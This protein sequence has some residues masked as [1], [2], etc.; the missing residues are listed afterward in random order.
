[1]LPASVSFWESSVATASDALFLHLL[2]SY[3]GLPNG[4]NPPEFRPLD[5]ALVTFCSKVS[6]LLVILPSLNALRQVFRRYKVPASVYLHIFDEFFGALAN[7]GVLQPLNMHMRKSVAD[8]H[9]FQDETSADSSDPAT[10]RVAVSLLTKNPVYIIFHASVEILQE[11]GFFFGLYRS[12]WARLFT[13]MVTVPFETVAV[14]FFQ[15]RAK[16]LNWQESVNFIR[17]L[18]QNVLLF[19]K[20]IL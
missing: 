9:L 7:H 20:A 6:Q 12:F 8:V 5:L 18:P 4:A 14:P 2:S 16:A 3:Y 1:M 19:F 17:N 13:L 15:A 11:S 10:S